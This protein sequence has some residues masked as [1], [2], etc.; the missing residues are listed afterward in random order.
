MKNSI[1]TKREC[2]SSGWHLFYLK[3]K[4]NGIRLSNYQ[5]LTNLLALDN[6]YIGEY[7]TKELGVLGGGF[8]VV[9]E[10]SEKVFLLQKSAYQIES[11]STEEMITINIPYKYLCKGLN[12]KSCL[13]DLLFI[14][15]R[16]SQEVGKENNDSLPEFFRSL[17]P[18]LGLHDIDELI[19]PDPERV[20]RKEKIF[21]FLHCTAGEV[22]FFI[23][24]WRYLLR[25][26]SIHSLHTNSHTVSIL[27][28]N[29]QDIYGEF[30]ASNDSIEWIV[31]TLM[32]S[33]G[34]SNSENQEYSEFV[35]NAVEEW[36]KYHKLLDFNLQQDNFIDE[37][38]QIGLLKNK[39]ITETLREVVCFADNFIQKVKKEYPTLSSVNKL[40]ER[41]SDIN[42]KIRKSS[43]RTLVF[44]LIDLPGEIYS[45][46][47]ET[48]DLFLEVFTMKKS[49]DHICTSFYEQTPSEK[50]KIL[51]SACRFPIL[52]YFYLSAI[53]EDK[54]AKEHL[55]FSSGRNYK[56][57]ESESFQDTID[58][59]VVCLLTISRI[60]NTCENKYLSKLN[61]IYSYFKEIS[62]VIVDVNFYGELVK[63][64]DKKIN[65][66]HIFTNLE[67]EL[68]AQF[69]ILYDSCNKTLNDPSES[70][71]NAQLMKSSLDYLGIFIRSGAIHKECCPNGKYVEKWINTCL[72]NSWKIHLVSCWKDI[73][74]EERR[75]DFFEL[76][77]CK[78]LDVLNINIII[79]ENYYFYWNDKTL[80]GLNNNILEAIDYLLARWLLASLIN[81]I[82]W[83]KDGDNTINIEFMV[84]KNGSNDLITIEILNPVDPAK[85]RIGDNMEKAT[86]TSFT[87]E[88]IVDELNQ[89]K[90]IRAENYFDEI[91]C[92]KT[93]AL[94]FKTS[95]TIECSSGTIVDIDY[96]SK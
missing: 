43:N 55:V 84:S 86:G 85:L 68:K 22:Y 57:Q 40:I 50:I 48:V 18:R 7:I 1:S 16:S 53:D 77:N 25:E 32:N 15:I 23:V 62:D 66:V 64:H 74:Y 59:P 28:E 96:Q 8:A 3:S 41:L 49:I 81:V 67:H 13:I 5:E 58:A 94:Q 42:V 51:H 95:L 44:K 61:T 36:D 30:Q 91:T 90:H 20:L 4:I 10:A 83:A 35:K 72:E 70:V 75:K 76:F 60:D 34:D 6:Q 12:R 80:P 39:K 88:R 65:N 71:V 17:P 73:S 78:S 56:W 26:V 89:I 27:D 69:C 19:L 82:K 31:Y 2:R 87:L 24:A 93:K 21:E 79:E 63:K 33:I 11:E 14:A 52:P 45:F 29:K 9:H 46:L 54:T 38:E 47:K 37:W 92:S